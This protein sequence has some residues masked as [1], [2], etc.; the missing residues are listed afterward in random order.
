MVVRVDRENRQLAATF[1]DDDNRGSRLRVVP[2]ADTQYFVED[3]VVSAEVFWQQL[4]DVPEFVFT[5]DTV[6]VSGQQINDIVV[7][8]DR[9]ALTRTY[10]Y[11][12]L[13]NSYLYADILG[14]SVNSATDVKVNVAFCTNVDSPR[15][16]ELSAVE[17][18]RS[19]GNFTMEITIRATRGGLG[20]NEAVPIPTF[21]MPRC[22]TP[23]VLAIPLGLD[24][25][26]A[27]GDYNVI[28]P[29]AT[30]IPG[31]TGSNNNP[32]ASFVVP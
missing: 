12:V 11:R 8:A 24:E 18:V 14:V 1:V 7:V 15:I 19:G 9:L 23:S 31:T 17:E 25:P 32:S 28:I 22:L 13:E 4:K 3:E 2:Q 21:P 10:G 20:F 6:I 5:S 30:G 27:S 26:L 29:G 16:Y